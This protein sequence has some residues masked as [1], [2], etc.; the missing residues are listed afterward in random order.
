M[1]KCFVLL[2]ILLAF[3]DGCITGEVVLDYGNETNKTSGNETS[4]VNQHADTLTAEDN[5]KMVEYDEKRL[6]EFEAYGFGIFN[7]SVLNAD[8]CKGHYEQM[9][10]KIHDIKDDVKDADENFINQKEDVDE[11]EKELEIVK[12]S[13]NENAVKHLEERIDREKDEMEEAEDFLEEISE[14]HRRHIVIKDHIKEYCLELK[15]SV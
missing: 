15:V 1:G 6:R 2:V 9:K 4:I 13:G 8:T 10:E 3:L 7:Y 11:L 12:Q 14:L 5:E